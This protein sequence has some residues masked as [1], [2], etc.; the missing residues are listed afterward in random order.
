MSNANDIMFSYGVLDMVKGKVI[1]TGAKPTIVA[2][3][4]FVSF[5]RANIITSLGCTLCKKDGDMRLYYSTE[6]RSN[7]KSTSGD[8]RNGSFIPTGNES[9]GE[10]NKKKNKDSI[11]IFVCSVDSLKS[12]YDQIK[13]NPGM[14]TPGYSKETL[15]NISEEWFTRT[16]ELLLTHRYDF[17]IK[18]KNSNSKIGSV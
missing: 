17:G 3:R 2:R 8:Q 10:A 14:L 7:S 12:A 6:T 18:K 9:N 13:S 11:F 4:T 1:Y 16:S 5:R 15:Q